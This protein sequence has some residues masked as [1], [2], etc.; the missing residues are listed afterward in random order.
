[1]TSILLDH[2]LAGDVVF[3]LSSLAKIGWLELIEIQFITFAE[4]GLAE[5]SSDREVWR[6]AQKPQMLLL[7]DN[8]NM[9]GDD[10]LEQTLRDEITG[11]SLPVLTI[12]DRDRL[13]EPDYRDKCATRLV[14]IIIDLNFYLG[15]SRLFMP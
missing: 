5:D 12:G 7:T 8:R 1:M 6:F 9:E 4:A 15:Y 11:E 13:L 10:S 2:N 14:E 3:L